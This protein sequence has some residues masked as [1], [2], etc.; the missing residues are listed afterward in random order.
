[1]K[2][3]DIQSALEALTAGSF[4][5]DAPAGKEE[6]RV[7]IHMENDYRGTMEIV[8]YRQDGDTCLCEV[9]GESTCFVSRNSVVE[10]IEAVNAIVL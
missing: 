8:L 10:L 2:I 3:D 4:T 7:V 6:I 1:M 9:N 5:G